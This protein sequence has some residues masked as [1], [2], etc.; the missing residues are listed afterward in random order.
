MPSDDL[1]GLGKHCFNFHQLNRICGFVRFDHPTDQEVLLF[2]HG[3]D[4]CQL[5]QQQFSGVQRVHIGQ[6][7]APVWH[8]SRHSL[9]QLDYLLNGIQNSATLKR[10]CIQI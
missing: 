5:G 9:C 3:L 10:I 4:C 1:L 8:F 2:G 6:I 7:S